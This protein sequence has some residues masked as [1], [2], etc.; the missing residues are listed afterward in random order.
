VHGPLTP[1][2]RACFAPVRL[3]ATQKVTRL[4]SNTIYEAVQI[5]NIPG[6]GEGAVGE[7]AVAPIGVGLDS[8]H[9][10]MMWMKTTCSW[11]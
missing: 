9:I 8:A 6:E 1:E 11:E 2:V 4:S 7:E 10:V 3:A 5:V